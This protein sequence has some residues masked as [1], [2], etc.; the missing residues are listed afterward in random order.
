MPVGGVKQ[1][2]DQ[3]GLMLVELG[4]VWAELY[5][6]RERGSPRRWSE[7]LSEQERD[8][9]GRRVPLP[10]PAACD[11]CGAARQRR[12]TCPGRLCAPLLEAPHNAHCARC[13]GLWHVRWSCPNVDCPT[14]DRFGERPV[15]LGESPAPLRPEALDM[16]ADLTCAVLALEDTVREVL[17]RNPRVDPQF[18]V[19]DP[20]E[21]QVVGRRPRTPSKTRRRGSWTVDGHVLRNVVVGQRP[22]GTDIV[23]RRRDKAIAGQFAPARRKTVPLRP[24]DQDPRV[25]LALTWLAGQL[26]A[27]RANPTLAGRVDDAL[28][29]TLTAA[30]GAIGS[31]ET[32][33]HLK[34][35]C[36]YCQRL[37][38]VVLMDRGII[39]CGSNRPGEPPRCEC[40]SPDCGCHDGGRHQ[41]DKEHWWTSLRGTGSE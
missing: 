36:P 2:P 15:P 9:A 13:G 41:W 11:M 12:W 17:G 30:R 21:P 1:D 35:P 3:M 34:Q 7:V 24:V 39:V 19:F 26:T 37:S 25:Q 38:L 8:A 33:K 29:R 31:S 5:R 40:P 28:H 20:H 27:I 18:D 16:I 4:E 32:V 22:D 6:Q 10:A 14:N 23:D